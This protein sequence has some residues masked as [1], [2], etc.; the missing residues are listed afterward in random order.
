MNKQRFA[1]NEDKSKI[2]ASQGHSIHVDL[3]LKEK[4]PPQYL[5]H[6]T[7][8]KAVASILQ[9]GLQKRTRQ[10]VHLSIDIPT[11]FS[12]GKRHGMPKVF[13]VAAQQ[14]QQDGF[15]FYLSENNVWLTANVPVQYIKLLDE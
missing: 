7:G 14:M 11:A 13:I 5:Y 10:H 12:I 15:T 9:S 4:V 6:G 3:Q 2:R 8:K 1:F